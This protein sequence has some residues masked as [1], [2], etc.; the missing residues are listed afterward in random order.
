MPAAVR[1]FSVTVLVLAAA[2]WSP[3]YAQRTQLKPGWNTF[4]PQQD[5]QVGKQAALDAQR[6]LPPCNL[7]RADAYLTQLG[8]KLV[9]HLNTGGT[10]YP[11]E[12]LARC[13]A[14]APA[15]R[16]SRN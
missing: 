9:A 7:P 5:I 15:G 13:L 11:W 12:F 4:S 10:E 16:C 8:K 1:R 3:A 6:Q 14:E 2:S